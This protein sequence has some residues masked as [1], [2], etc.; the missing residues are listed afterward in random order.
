MKM[1]PKTNKEE[2]L[3][4]VYC[5]V[6]FCGIHLLGKE[7]PVFLQFIPGGFILCF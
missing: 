3:Y 6:C 4:R 2:N 1:F 5:T 7:K